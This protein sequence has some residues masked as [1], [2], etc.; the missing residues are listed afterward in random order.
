MALRGENVGTAYVRIL[1]DGTGLADDIRDD[2]EDTD[3]VFDDA[4][5]RHAQTYD[6]EFR[7]Q[8]KRD[9]PGN[10]EALTAMFEGHTQRIRQITEEMTTTYFKNIER[11]IR[12]QAGNNERLGDRLAQQL[13]KG[14]VEGG[15]YAQWGKDLKG[16]FDQMP[17][18][19]AAALRDLNAIDRRA[20][21]T[22]PGK[23]V[24]E[25]VKEIGDESDTA[26]PRLHRF[27][28]RLRDFSGTVANS[29][30]RGSRNDFINFF[31]GMVG[32]FTGLPAK[33]GGAIESIATFGKSFMELRA[34]GTGVF[35]ALRGAA[36]GMASLGSSAAAAAI[37]IPIVVV[38]VGTLVAALSLLLGV[39]VALAS[40]LANALVGALA[41]V[42][43]A[44]LPV[45]AA[46][47]VVGIAIAGMSDA[48][49]KAVKEAFKPMIAG[50]KEIGAAAADSIFGDK[51][52]SR[53]MQERASVF[54]ESVKRMTNALTSS[55]MMTLVKNIGGAISDVGAGWSK[56]LDSPGFRRFVDT[57]A[58]TLPKQVRTLGHIFDRVGAA[59]GNT[60]IAMQPLVQ[61][62]LDWLDDVT[63][64]W[65][66]WTGTAEGQDSM[67]RFFDRAQDSLK[68]VGHF[69]KEVG[70]LMKD[71]LFNTTGQETGNT[72]FD[73]M[74]DGIAN[75]RDYIADGGLEKWFK[76]AKEFADDL[77]SAIKGI[78]QVLDTLDSPGF[79]SFAGFTIKA[80]AEIMETTSNL[81][82]PIASLGEAFD[83][84]FSGDFSG[85]ASGLLKA[86]S[87]IG[88][89]M[90]DIL[91]F[92]FA[93]EILGLFDG[94]DWGQIGSDI[95]NGLTEG[96]SSAWSGFISFLDG[97]WQ[98]M[99]DS[100]RSF[101]GIHSPSTL[102]A[103]FGV[104]MILGLLQ[105]L[106]GA[107][108]GL[109]TYFVGLGSQ[110]LG[111]LWQGLGDL[112]S[113][114]GR[115]IGEIASGLT[116]AIPS[117]GGVANSILGPLKQPLGSG[118]S[119]VR[120]K[121]SELGTFLKNDLGSAFTSA[122]TKAGSLGSRLAGDLSSKI[123]TAKSR[124]G[125]L[126][127]ATRDRLG[128]AFDSAR[129]KAGDLANK[130]PG[131]SS[132]MRTA[133]TVAGNIRNAFSGVRDAIG[134][135]IDRVQSLISWLGRIKVPSLNPGSGVPFVPGIKTGGLVDMFGLHRVQKMASGGLA[136]FAQNY[137]IGEA[138]RE[139]IVPLDRPLGQVDPAVR[140]LSAFAQGKLTGFGSN[141]N[142][143][144]I[145]A[146]GWQ[147]V[148]PNDGPTVAREVLDALVANID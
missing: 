59:I 136:N 33:V 88:K 89:G 101:F 81:F 118:F 65:A 94:V 26:M 144:S 139:A 9:R 146:S 148:S 112:M 38:V 7:K 129:S 125:E 3:E 24:A 105:G 73:N 113:F 43:G 85:F 100:V 140:M 86:L 122:G 68:S 70:G 1:A 16:L 66:K 27:N 83:S 124:A 114:G 119:W 141:D 134:W 2:L 67:L 15:G 49:K 115:F 102:F 92:G 8:M 84:L 127:S 5:K 63:T 91:S 69:L 131:L 58:E 32:F 48:Q 57:M 90:L 77:G 19:Y 130:I 40:A 107:A 109:G 111:W 51:N 72:L 4:G 142:S 30:G 20:A 37:A 12:R 104:D 87:D 132:A 80:L 135:V 116:A 98:N 46:F 76:D 120:G 103:S 29:F 50:F 41:A 42:A 45:I 13:R 56:S 93:D 117:L 96:I 52:G 126:A 62:F 78:G 106:A 128:S 110:F 10:Q 97:L 35:A 145:D 99:V 71:L 82:A 28:L 39:V 18:W 31:G 75:F 108:L 143:R 138:G 36:G 53:A 64:S 22:A 60:F 6:D 14:F 47:G 95:I 54:E 55:N 25:G 17:G 79:R 61:N 23:A 74:A 44:L 11:N 21:S 133:V 147:I 137:Q 34:A 123:G 121:A